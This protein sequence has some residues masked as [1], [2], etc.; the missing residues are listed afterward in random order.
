MPG[1]LTLYLV[2]YGKKPGDR[3]C[4]FGYNCVTEGENVSEMYLATWQARPDL[5]Q[6]FQQAAASS[7]VNRGPSGTSSQG[8]PRARGAPDERAARAVNE[9]RKKAAARGLQVRP[10]AA[11]P[12]QSMPPLGDLLS[13][14]NSGVAG[15]A[16]LASSTPSSSTRGG[17]SKTAQTGKKPATP[18][19]AAPATIP[20]AP[21]SVPVSAVPNGPVQA[22]AAAADVSGPS[23]IGLGNGLGG[24]DSKKKKSKSKNVAA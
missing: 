19:A 23:P 15:K 3:R 14:I 12:N 11:A 20:T 5:V 7:S 4:V 2:S 24:L 9:V 8:Q 6:V 21:K 22:T 16:P 13:L 17:T 1:Y 18:P 10:Q